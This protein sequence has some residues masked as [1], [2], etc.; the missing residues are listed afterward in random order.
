LLLFIFVA[1][2]EEEAGLIT[3]FP[4]SLLAQ[5]VFGLLFLKTDFSSK[6]FPVVLLALL[7]FGLF[8]LQFKFK[9]FTTGVDAFGLFDLVLYNFLSGLIVWETYFQI[10]RKF[11]FV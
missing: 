4:G 3:L 6:L 5:F 11:H 9:F 2:V 10:N 8:M 7:S 1:K